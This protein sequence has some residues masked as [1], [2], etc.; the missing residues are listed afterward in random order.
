M[1]PISVAA[2]GWSVTMVGWVASATISRLLNKCFNYIDHDTKKK[3][4]Q[5][6]PKILVLERVMEI[7]GT[8]PYRPRL[9]QL[10]KELKTAYYEA[11]E[12]LDAV[13]YHCLDRQIQDSKLQP[14]G[15]TPPPKK[16]HLKKIRSAM[17][18]VSLAKNK[19]SGM[20][21]KEL[22]KSLK[23]IEDVINEAYQILDKLNLSN[24]SNDN[25]RHTMVVSPPTT[26]VS[27]QKVF[28]RDDDRDKI[29]AMLHEKYGP[30]HP[31]TSNNPCFSVIGI[32]G[33][34]GSGKST[35]AQLVYA[36]EKKDK[37]DKKE[38]YFDLVMWV[39][40]SQNFSVGVI[41]NE[42]YEAASEPKVPCPQFNN[43]NALG[44]ELERKLEGKRFLLVLDDVWCNKDVGNEELPKLLSPLKKGKRGSK[45]LVTTRSKFALSD[46]GPGVRYTA[47]PINEVNDTA[48]FEL[49]MHYALEG[50]QDQSMFRKI[51]VEIAKKLKG[52]PLAARTVGGNL[53]RQP[54]VDH[55]RRV[56]DQDLFKVWGGPLWW[57]YYQLGEQAR[58]CFAYCSIFPRRHRWYRDDLVSFWMAE[59]FIRSTD[60]G[61]DIEDVGQEIFNELLSISFLQ[62]GGMDYSV[63]KEYY[64]V[65]DL[66]HDL[67][68]AV[69]GSD[70]FR[71]DNN[72]SQKGGGWTGDVPRDVR[73][74]F[75][76][77]YDAALITGKIL[78]LRNLHT[79]II[80]SVGGDTP[81]E[82]IVIKNILKSLPKLR[83]LAIA[84]D[85]EKDAFI[86]GPNREK[87]AFICGYIVCP[88]IYGSIKASTLSWF[89]EHSKPALPGAAARFW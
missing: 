47:M 30:I 17:A 12:I 37:Q 70:C 85:R 42:M 68:E 50:G 35:L 27:P 7:V 86:C 56:G 33:V 64:L 72:T 89:T 13:E 44:E 5:L 39:H 81:V 53:R 20:S 55:W 32:H 80:Y 52:S 25:R 88:R 51:G 62:P 41:F 60:E 22:I 4:A 87:D 63:K 58:R 82:E 10:F 2:V 66:L 49:F 1:D 74:L 19:E 45:I 76:Q 34:G 48:F 78:K 8:S 26:A 57:S 43:L 40:V 46:L 31:S 61:G 67:A 65:H 71:I 29:I 83:L 6:E 3:L 21:N 38:G 23:R 16:N 36:H 59:G 24:I 28:G 15:S 11:E 54:D 84:F 9:E 18:K 69:A 73:H 79:L 77:N 14:G 75:V